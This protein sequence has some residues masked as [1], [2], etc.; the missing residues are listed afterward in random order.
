M[1]TVRTTAKLTFTAALTLSEVEIRALD[2]LVGYGDD[3]FIEAF[4]AKLGAAYL[5]NHEQG[6]RSAFAAI[7]RDCLP[8]LREIDQAR[9]AL[10]EAKIGAAS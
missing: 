3:A 2:A 5:R 10:A 7:R 4:K 9:K 1:A 8:A 6:L